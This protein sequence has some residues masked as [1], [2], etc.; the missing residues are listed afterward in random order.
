MGR[1]HSYLSLVPVRFSILL[2]FFRVPVRFSILL[3]FFRAPVRFSI[4][5]DFENSIPSNEVIN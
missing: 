3:D 1:T 5:L 4:L 2:D